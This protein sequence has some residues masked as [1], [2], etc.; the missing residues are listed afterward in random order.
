MG[1]IRQG[2]RINKKSAISPRDMYPPSARVIRRGLDAATLP[3][4]GFRVADVGD[5]EA[6]CTAHGQGLGLHHDVARWIFR[7]IVETVR[8]AATGLP[9]QF[10]RRSRP[11]RRFLAMG[12]G[13]FPGD[14]LASDIR[15]GEQRYR[16]HELDDVRQPI[17]SLTLERYVAPEEAASG[18]EHGWGG[19]ECGT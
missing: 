1:C 8:G 5:S 10:G 2:V 16:L 17:A 3:R 18:R 6:Y 12:R 4:P 15:K 19:T 14:S 9:G 7:Q 11:A 13:C